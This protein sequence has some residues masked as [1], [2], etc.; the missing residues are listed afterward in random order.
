MMSPIFLEAK[1]P[2]GKHD[3]F[4]KRLLVTSMFINVPATRVILDCKNVNSVRPTTRE[5]VAHSM[6][7][8]RLV[9][10][11]AIPLSMIACDR[12][13]NT[14]PIPDIQIIENVTHT[15]FNQ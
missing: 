7:T 5:I 10:F 8:N 9:F 12:K 3:N 13:G 11:K 4:C 2:I 1:N 6:V 14:K 15:I